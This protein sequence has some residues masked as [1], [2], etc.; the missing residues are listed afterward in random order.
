MNTQDVSRT[1]SLWHVSTWP[2]FIAH[3]V[4]R[5]AKE[6]SGQMPVRM[7]KRQMLLAAQ[8][9][10]RREQRELILG[11]LRYIKPRSRDNS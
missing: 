11:Q 8:D 4:H 3:I 1:Q 10:K 6:P 2:G 7:T 5:Q 9:L